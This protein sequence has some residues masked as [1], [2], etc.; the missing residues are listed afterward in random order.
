MR[1]R[2]NALAVNG[3]IEG[4][5]HRYRAADQAYL[6]AG[7]PLMRLTVLNNLA[8]SEHLAGEAERALAAA[9]LLRELAEA[10]EN[11]CELAIGVHW[12]VA[13]DVVEDVGLGQIVQRV[14][15]ANGDCR[16]K[17]AVAQAVEKHV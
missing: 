11:V 2:G 14:S 16:G 5:R 8:Y 17:S 9:A 7:R 1:Q 4:A 3:D 15:V 13:G 10:N 12:H 6:A